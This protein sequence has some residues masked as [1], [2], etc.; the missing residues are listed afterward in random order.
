MLYRSGEGRQ[1]AE[2]KQRN[3]C[4]MLLTVPVVGRSAE[5]F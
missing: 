4:I 5:F 2:R 1:E 3:W